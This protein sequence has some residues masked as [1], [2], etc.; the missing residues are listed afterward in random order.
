MG[1]GRRAYV[2]GRSPISL[3]LI[4]KEK[5]PYLAL[6][7][8]LFLLSL[9]IFPLLLDPSSPSHAPPSHLP[10]DAHLLLT[11]LLATSLIR[12]PVQ[13][14]LSAFTYLPSPICHQSH[15]AKPY[16][17]NPQPKHLEHEALVAPAARVRS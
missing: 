11:P 6:R 9:F 16:I 10:P 14:Y 12:E 13:R 5:E 17:L 7:E 4:I 8:S 1:G 15:A 3:Y 2:G